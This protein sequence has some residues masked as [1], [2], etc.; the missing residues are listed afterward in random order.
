[1]NGG[2]PN[3]KSNCYLSDGIY[4]GQLLDRLQNNVTETNK[5]SFFP[6]IRPDLCGLNFLQTRYLPVL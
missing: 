3:E 4:S 2:K 1:M 5:A 6:R